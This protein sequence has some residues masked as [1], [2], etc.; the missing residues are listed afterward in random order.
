MTWLLQVYKRLSRA[1][2]VLDGALSAVPGL[3]PAA[4]GLIQRLLQPSPTARPGEAMAATVSRVLHAAQLR[5]TDPAVCLSA[6]LVIS[7]VMALMP[8][9]RHAGLRDVWS[10]PFLAWTEEASLLARQVPAPFVPHLTSPL[11]ALVSQSMGESRLQGTSRAERWLRMWG[12][13]GGVGVEQ[14]RKRRTR[15]TTRTTTRVKRPASRVGAG[16]PAAK[17]TQA[18]VHL[19]PPEAKRV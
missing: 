13:S 5:P 9:V 8:G 7:S 14:E 15:R 18:K 2:T 4:R 6:W 19:P 3:D 1:S 17:A 12:G 16:L 11:D 10:E